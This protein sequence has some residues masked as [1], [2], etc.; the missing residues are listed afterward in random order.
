M[1]SGKNL[2]RLLL[3]GLFALAAPAALAPFASEP[4]PRIRIVAPEFVPLQ[5]AKDGAAR[6][7][8]AD[9][10]KLVIDRVAEETALTTTA[11]EIVPWRRAIKI[12]TESPNVL[13]FSLSRTKKREDKFIWVGEVSPYEVFFSD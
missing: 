8:V 7:Y 13:M 1:L 10:A 5:L 11:I 6:G 3:A 4:D 2:H 9:L 12:A